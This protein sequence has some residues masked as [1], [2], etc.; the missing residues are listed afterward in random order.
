MIQRNTKGDMNFWLVLGALALIF[1]F[2]VFFL[3]TNIIGGFG[4]SAGKVQTEIDKD[5]DKIDFDFVDAGEDADNDE[6]DEDE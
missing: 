3:M 2:V 6:V 1:M 4:E 5:I